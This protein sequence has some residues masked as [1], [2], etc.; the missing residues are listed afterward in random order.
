MQTQPI[1]KLIKSEQEKLNTDKAAEILGLKPQTL[2]VW[3]CT[4]K[5][6]IAYYK[7]GRKVF[8][9][10]CDLETFMENNRVA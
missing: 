8:Y 9:L 1:E 5:H 6:K 3:R 2:K 4:G 7:I 10:R